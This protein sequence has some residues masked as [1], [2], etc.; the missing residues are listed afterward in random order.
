ME[1]VVGQIMNNGGWTY[2]RLG[3]KFKNEHQCQ[4]HIDEKMIPLRRDWDNSIDWENKL[5]PIN[6]NICSYCG[7]EL[8]GENHG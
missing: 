8:P 4:K 3:P 1:W 6:P 7:S 5:K 2:N